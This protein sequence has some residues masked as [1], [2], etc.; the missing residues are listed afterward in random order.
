MTCALAVA[1][2]NI[3]TAAVSKELVWRQ[4]IN[5]FE[6]KEICFLKQISTLEIVM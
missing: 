3:N 6:S 5:L 2:K 4:A 1:V